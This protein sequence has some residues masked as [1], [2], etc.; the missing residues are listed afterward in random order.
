M[1]RRS[2]ARKRT[3][4]ACVR[5]CASACV[6]ARPL[7][8]VCACASACVRARSRARAGVHA[9]VCVRPSVLVYFARLCL[10]WALHFLITVCACGAESRSCCN[11]FGKLVKNSGTRLRLT[12]RLVPSVASMPKEAKLCRR[13]GSAQRDLAWN[14]WAGRQMAWSEPAV[15]DG[16]R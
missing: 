4:R 3:V 12:Q 6:R 16:V 15:S 13:S 8:C 10:L 5:A 1:K 2:L 7:A 11:L 14:E 9:R